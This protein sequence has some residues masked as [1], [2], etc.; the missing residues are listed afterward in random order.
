MIGT[1]TLFEYPIIRGEKEMR[2]RKEEELASHSLPENGLGTTIRAWRRFRGMTVTDLAVQAGFGKN[3]RGYISRIEHGQIRRLGEERLNCIA[4]A[5][6][7]E[8]ADLLLHRM[9]E[10]HE[11]APVQ[12]LDDAIIGGKALLKECE[13]QSFDWARIQLLLAKLYREHANASHTTVAKYAALTE[14][15]HCIECS[16]RVFTVSTAPR[17]FQE[18]MQLGQ[19]IGEVLDASI[20]VGSKALL[21]RCPPQSL[22]WARIQLLLA[23]FYCEHAVVLQ[24]L[25]AVTALTE[26]QHCIE[27]A[28]PIFTQRKGY[29]SLKEARQL[30]QEITSTLTQLG[31]PIN[32]LP[33]DARTKNT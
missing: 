6:H 11:G 32:R 21:K 10:V 13:E 25:E 7:L 26:A 24:D 16:L 30:Y 20:I 5:L 29:H 27:A 15:Q 2:G 14:A 12:D 4:A 18:A 3:N 19:E 9:P 8:R 31:E 22:D 23:K 33:L 28:V 17:S 1:L